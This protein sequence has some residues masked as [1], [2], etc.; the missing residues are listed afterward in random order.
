M[1]N[2]PFKA[3]AD[4]LNYP[5]VTDWV[6]LGGQLVTNFDLDKLRSDIGNEKL[7]NWDDIHQRYDELW[8]R[9]PLDKQ[10]HAYACLCI[11]YGVK[12]ISKDNW[13]KALDKMIELQQ[14]I[15]EQVYVTRKKDYENKF[16]QITFRN[17]DEMNAALGTIEQNSFIVEVG[18][19]TKELIDRIGILKQL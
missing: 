14:Y 9:Y 18:R 8:E 7:K 12:V 1:D 11:L 17:Q 16:R 6:N 3:M 4:A 13:V 15:N 19:E 5:R 2:H 10:K